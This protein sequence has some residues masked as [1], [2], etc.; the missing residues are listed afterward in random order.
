M[1]LFETVFQEKN[2]QLSIIVGLGLA[3]HLNWKI[4]WQHFVAH[5]CEWRQREKCPALNNHSE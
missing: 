3:L 5:V 2:Q 4:T 1:L